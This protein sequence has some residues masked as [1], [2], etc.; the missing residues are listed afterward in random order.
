[1]WLQDSGEIVSYART[2]YLL[3]KFHQKKTEL[4]PPPTHT[5]PFYFNYIKYSNF[6]EK[7]IKNDLVTPFFFIPRHTLVAGYY[8][9]TLAICL[10]VRP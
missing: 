9:F 1:M 5:H 4:C 2:N 7:S 8:I 10:S 3:G 6:W